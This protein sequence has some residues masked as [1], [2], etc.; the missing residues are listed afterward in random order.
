MVFI[1]SHVVIIAACLMVLAVLIV[2]LLR[3]P[4]SVLLPAIIW[5]ASKT[6]THVSY[7]LLMAKVIGTTTVVSV[8]AI[9]A[10]ASLVSSICL[11][12]VV[13]EWLRTPSV[14][15]MRRATDAMAKTISTLSEGPK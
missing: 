6:V 4:H 2:A 5:L 7:L 15:D 14:Q 8:V 3:R 13:A 9:N 1:V 12:V 11:V 10:A